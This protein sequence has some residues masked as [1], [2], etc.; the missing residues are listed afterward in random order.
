MFYNSKLDSLT[1]RSYLAATEIS[2]LEVMNRSTVAEALTE[3][4]NLKYTRMLVTDASGKV[5]YDTSSDRIEGQYAL[6]PEIYHALQGYD[7]FYWDYQEGTMISRA[8]S[9]I[10][11]YRTVIGSVYLMDYDTDQGAV[12]HRLQINTLF[13]SMVLELSM[14]LFSFIFAKIYNF[15]LRKLMNSIRVIREGNYSHKVKLMGNDELSVLGSEFNDMTDRLQSSENIRR[16][17]VSD[18][19]H[20]LKTPLASIKLL[21][22]SILQNDMDTDTIKEFV[23]DIGQEAER[24]NRM[25]HKLLSLSQLED[26]SESEF[27]ITNIEPTIR[28]VVRMVHGLVESSQITV[29]IQILDDTNI[30][31]HEDDLYQIIFNLTEN[32]IKYN[33]Q[34]GKLTLRLERIDDNALLTISDTGVGIPQD[35]LDQIFER[36]YRV[37]KAR[38]RQSGGSGLG[39][40]IVKSMVLR[41]NG[42]IDVTSELGIGTTF[43]I[44]FPAFDLE[45]RP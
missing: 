6:F 40:S 16:Q 32:A 7:V 30:L 11:A 20:E 31:I 24:L 35:S 34:N 22:D 1:D 15:R 23:S 10:I 27:E 44:R 36:F 8:A 41:N 12:L 19:S 33:R 18:A 14:I 9:P 39:L 21:S 5:I 26:S 13:L 3:L 43:T 45:D 4:E 29:D 25:S 42:A 38:S 17:F 28:K 2:H 37:D